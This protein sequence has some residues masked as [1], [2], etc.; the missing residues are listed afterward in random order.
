M[1]PDSVR[2]L[3]DLVLKDMRIYETVRTNIYTTYYITWGTFNW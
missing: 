3:E 1:H 2:K